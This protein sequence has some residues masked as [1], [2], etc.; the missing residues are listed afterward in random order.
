MTVTIGARL[1]RFASST[2]VKSSSLAASETAPS[3]PSSV[4]SP[5]VARTGSATSYPSSPA[6]SAAV[7]RSMSWLIVAKIP[8]LMSSRITSAGLT[9]NRSASSLTVMVAGSSIAPR[10]RGS[11][12]W[13]LAPAN[14]PSRRGGLRGPRRPRVPLLLLA[15][16]P[17]SDVVGRDGRGERIQE[18]RR[19]RG[20]EDPR[21]GSP[22]DGGGDAISIATDVGAPAGRAPGVVGAH[23]PVR[24]PNDAQQVALVACGPAGNARPRRG[25]PNRRPRPVSRP[26]LTEVGG[27]APRRHPPEVY[28]TTSSVVGFLARARGVFG[29]AGS[30][31]AV[32]VRARGFF[33]A[34]ADAAASAGAA[35]TTGSV[36]SSDSVASAFF[37]RARGFFAAAG[38][39]AAA[40]GSPP[41]SATAGSAAA[42]SISAPAGPAAPAVSA[43]F[44]SAAPTAPPLSMGQPVR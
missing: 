21:E 26:S 1:M 8:L 35:A 25:A 17:S 34:T 30:A 13:T 22:L 23:G 42:A 7:S 29:A 24:R 41:A 39:A 40:I 11:T 18:R 36:A 38:L 10:S 5:D 3:A 28:D 44:A 27:G 14:A 32:A 15:T 19:D 43:A 16:G 37:V 31:A 20:L 12:V 9:P 4:P 33:S 6:T 2:S